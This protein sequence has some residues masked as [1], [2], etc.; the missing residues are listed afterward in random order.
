MAPEKTTTLRE[1]ARVTAE[2]T[3][4][5]ELANRALVLVGKIVADTVRRY[6]HLLELRRERDELLQSAATRNAPNPAT[7]ARHER[8]EEL[9]EDIGR[10][11]EALNDLHRE[12]LATGCVLK[13]WH[14]GMVDFPAVHE[15]RRIWLCWRLGEPAVAHWHEWHAGIAG[16]RPLPS[17]FE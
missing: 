13:D 4:T 11:A 17:N 9:N 5:P 6:K 14:S 10:C 15:G 3:F 16:R 12:L 7:A 2:P 8:M 1:A